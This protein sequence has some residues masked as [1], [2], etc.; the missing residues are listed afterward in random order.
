MFF[1]SFVSNQNF[2][3]L[4]FFQN[5]FPSFNK[6]CTYFLSEV[7]SAT[8]LNM[9]TFFASNFFLYKFIFRMQGARESKWGLDS[10][11]ERHTNCVRTFQRNRVGARR[12]ERE[13]GVVRGWGSPALARKKMA[14]ENK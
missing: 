10:V 11:Q 7:F 3:C 9:W 5:I 6:L 2:I 12:E 8:Y 4:F 13:M 1:Q 14:Q